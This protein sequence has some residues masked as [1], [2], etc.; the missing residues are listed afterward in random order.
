M[1]RLDYRELKTVHGHMM[2][3]SLHLS[4]IQYQYF[5]YRRCHDKQSGA[6]NEWTNEDVYVGCRKILYNSFMNEKG[7]KIFT[8]NENEIA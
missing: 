1:S 6:T 8:M 4:D 3:P 7:R 2:P 5:F